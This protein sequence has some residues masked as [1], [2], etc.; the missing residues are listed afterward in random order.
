MQ[1]YRTGNP[2]IDLLSYFIIENLD[3]VTVEDCVK[4]V[5]KFKELKKNNEIFCESLKNIYKLLES[6]ID[7]D[8]VK[9]KCH[10]CKQKININTLYNHRH[11]FGK[12]IEV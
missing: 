8:D 7:N 2:N 4:S 5:L 3:A 10:S 9:G 12:Y 11:C 6:C 1:T